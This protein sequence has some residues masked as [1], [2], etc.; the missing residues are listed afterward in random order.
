MRVGAWRKQD[1]LCFTWEDGI[2]RKREVL[3]A[4]G[5]SRSGGY[6]HN[7]SLSESPVVSLHPCFVT[8]ADIAQA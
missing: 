4:N 3:L 7:R 1:M 5:G 8:S 2:E 6:G